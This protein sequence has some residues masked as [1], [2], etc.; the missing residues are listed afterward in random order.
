MAEHLLALLRI[1]ESATG[2]LLRQ[3][4]GAAVRDARTEV[5]LRGRWLL[6]RR[7]A[8]LDL[9][10]DGVR[11]GELPD[12]VDPETILDS[13]V[14]PIYHRLMFRLPPMNDRDVLDLLGIVWPPAATRSARVGPAPASSD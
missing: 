8:A 14:A 9:I 13:M 11:R 2:E 10:V 4:L 1:T 3:A 6:P 5:E 12:D 7:S